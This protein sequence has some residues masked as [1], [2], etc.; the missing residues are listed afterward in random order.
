MSQGRFCLEAPAEGPSRLFRL[1]GAPGVRPWAGGCLPPVSSSDSTWLLLCVRV[2]PLLCLI[3][4]LSLGLGPAKRTSFHTLHFISSAETLCPNKFPFQESEFG[5]HRFR[6]GENEIREK[7]RAP[8]ISVRTGETAG[9]TPLSADHVAA[10]LVEKT[11]S[12][13][14]Y[15]WPDT[16]FLQQKFPE[17]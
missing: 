5:G 2:S 17:D 10:Q 8:G 14:A 1:L 7:P 16:S 9:L 15:R 12:G 6:A 4:T 3:R 13:P 11:Q